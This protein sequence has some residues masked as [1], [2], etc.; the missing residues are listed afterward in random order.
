MGVGGARGK[1][2]P[3]GVLLCLGIVSVYRERAGDK[4]VFFAVADPCYC[5]GVSRCVTVERWEVF[6]S[7]GTLRTGKGIIEMK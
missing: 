6:C 3:A 4:V 2:V 1:G 7:R 5:N